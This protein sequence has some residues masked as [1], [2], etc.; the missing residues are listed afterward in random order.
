MK[1]QDGDVK[2]MSEGELR[3]EVMSLR[4]AIR[5][6]RDADENARCWHNDLALYGILPEEVPPGK[7]QGPE[8]ELLKN[9]RRYIRRQQCCEHGCEHC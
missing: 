3:R 7:M 1:P 5:Q 4:H 6:H 8:E 9:C 2:K